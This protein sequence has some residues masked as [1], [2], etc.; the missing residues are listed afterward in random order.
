MRVNIAL[1][2]VPKRHPVCNVPVHEMDELLLSRSGA[3]APKPMDELLL[4][5]SGTM[6][7]K[8]LDLGVAPVL[9]S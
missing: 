2:M 4:N 7:P 5:R 3:M 9:C 1:R 8:P 6:A